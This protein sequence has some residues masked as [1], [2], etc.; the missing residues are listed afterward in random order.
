[1]AALWK[2]PGDLHHARTTATAWAPRSSA[3]QRDPRHLRARR[4]SYDMAARSVRR[5]GRA[6]RC[7]PRW[8]ARSSARA[9][10]KHPTLLEVRTYRFMGHSMSDPIH[11][12]LP[13]QGRGRGAAE[14][15]S[16]RGLVAAAASRTGLMDE[17]AV[18]GARRGGQGGG[19]GRLR[20]R[21]RGAGSGAEAAVRRTC[22]RRYDERRRTTQPSP[23]VGAPMPIT[24]LPRRPQPGAARGDAARRPRLPHGRGGRRLPGR[25][26][27][28]PQGLLEE[29][30]EM[31]VVDT[32]ITELGFAGVGVGAAMVGLRPV[33]EF[34]TW[35]F[36]LLAST[37]SSTPPPRC[38]TCRA[39]SSTCPIVFRGPGGAALQLGAQHSQ[40]FE[41]WLRPHPR[42][43]GR[44]AGD[45]GRRQGAAQERDPRRQP[46]GLHRGRDA[47]QHQGRGPRGRAHRPARQGR[48]EAR[49]RATSPSSATRKMVLGRAQ[50]RRAA[51]GGRRSTPRSSTCARSGRWTSRRCSTSVA[52]TNRCVVARGRLAVRRRRRAGGGLRSSARLRRARRAG[53]A[54]APAPTC[55]CRTTST[56]RRP[57][58]PTPPRSIAAVHA[59]DVPRLSDHG[60]QSRHGGALPHDGRGAPRQVEEERRRRRS[61][62]ATCSPRS[63]P[64]RRSWSWWPARAARC[65]SRSCRPAPRC[66]SPQLVALIG[67]PGEIGARTAKPAAARSSAASAGGPSR[68]PSSRSLCRATGSGRAARPQPRR[69]PAVPAAVAAPTGG[70][71]SRRPRSRAGSRPSAGSTSAASRAPAP[72]AASSCATSRERAAPGPRTR[73]GAPRRR[74]PP[75]RPALRSS[76]WRRRTRTCRSPRSARRSRSGSSSR[77]GPIPTFYLTTEVDMERAWEAREALKAAGRR[78]QGLVQRHHHQGRGHRAPAAPG[79]QRLVAGRPD[80][81]L[82]RGP[83][84]H[85]GGDRGRADHAGDPRRRPQALREIAAEAHDLAGRARER[86]LKPEEYTGGTFSV[87]NLGM[88]DIDEFTAVINPPEAGIL[89]VGRIVQKPV[90]HDGQSPSRRRLRLT[91]SCDH[92][93]IDGATGAQFLKTLK[94]MLENPLALVWYPDVSERTA[95]Q[96]PN[97]DIC[98]DPVRRDHPR[99]RTRRLRLRHPR[100]PAR[101][102]HR[103]GRAGQARRRVRQHRVHPDQG[104]AAQRLRREPGR[105]TTP[106]SSASRSAASRPTTASPC[107]GRARCA[108]RTRRASSS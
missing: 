18:Q 19:G 11:G 42:P 99:R 57:R 4:C 70:A 98:G 47:L 58:R 36:A 63:R 45:A 46:G 85:G 90:A 49:R 107:G 86:R 9:S 104:A 12:T 53:P 5:A 96:L 32:P 17:A 34:M 108:S 28:E 93:V 68:R 72:R 97:E 87:S 52:K 82:A 79:V 48:G 55:R 106:R 102:G 94:A 3:R 105:R 74:R 66:R 44:H 60:N 21:R 83:R 7:T 26:Q 29:F 37:R 8:S 43:Q 2:L 20:V 80:P 88:L 71:G 59:S 89:A 103:R 76:R 81:L 1:M 73:R 39:A 40:A 24:D 16:D 65:S 13:H 38:A 77:S 69:T 23:D 56:S 61:P 41:S 62:S 33:I 78:A 22:M 15:R 95:P 91:M 25:L 35:N 30:G 50:G 14:A 10:D 6:G 67:E 101:A 92:R 51:R 64:T 54:R 27:G 75:P 31:R 84:R 100:G